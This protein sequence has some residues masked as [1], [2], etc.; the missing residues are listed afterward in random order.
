MPRENTSVRDK[1]YNFLVRNAP[2]LLN[3][4]RKW[5]RG[6]KRRRIITEG[7]GD[8]ATQESLLDDLRQAGIAEGD[9]V[10]AHTILSAMGYVEGGAGTVVQALLQAIGDEGTLVM[11]CFAHDTFSKYYLDKDP[12][13]DV[14]QSPSRAGSVTE[15]MRLMP[16]AVRSFHPTDAVCALGPL[17]GWLVADHFG[18][19]TP[20][21]RQS[22][23][24]RVGEK[25]GKILCIGVPLLT[26]CTNL[27]TLE[28]AVEFRYPVYHPDVY[29]ARMRDENGVERRMKTRVHDPAWSMKRRPDD[30]VPLFEKEGI[31][32]KVRIARA[33]TYLIDAAGL[34]RVMVKAYND[35]GITMYTP[36]GRED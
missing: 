29:E 22:P 30:L 19:I 14:T 13:F 17:A 27:H 25:Q 1:L 34:F 18:Q 24:F 4:L 9:L 7:T 21:N 20:Y 12:V 6:R 36:F 35:D 16:G 32:R 2:G 33:D 15:A 23:Y 26:S 11:P 8:P 31:L 5:K 10:I 3:Q 28:D